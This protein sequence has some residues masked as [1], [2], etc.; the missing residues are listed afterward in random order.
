MV[1]EEESLEEEETVVEVVEKPVVKPV[2]EEEEVEVT[3][4]KISDPRLVEILLRTA[5]ILEKLSKKEITL[6]EAKAIYETE[7]ADLIKKV[8]EATS[9]AS[10]RTSAKK[11]KTQ[12]KKKGKKKG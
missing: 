3:Y 11:K 7:V 2:E 5:D 12:S 8:T 10:Q 4:Y 1:S 9:K 6:S